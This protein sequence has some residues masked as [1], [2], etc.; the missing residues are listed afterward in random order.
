[1]SINAQ[2]TYIDNLFS[3]T[4]QYRVPRYQRRYVWDETNWNRL[5]EDILIQLKEAKDNQ[6]DVEEK[7]NPEHFTGPIVTCPISGIAYEVIDGQQRLATFQIILCVIRDLC[8]TQNT[9]E[10][11][12]LAESAAR[13]MV[14]DA[15][16]IRANTAHKFK[17]VPTDHDRDTFNLVASGKY[18]QN[19][20]ASDKEHYIF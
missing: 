3:S 7:D 19:R 5:W 4:V 11:R 20:A 16:T 6:L 2:G 17:L 12:D 14:N 10:H 15:R 9:L 13:Y 1:M 8:E 18:A